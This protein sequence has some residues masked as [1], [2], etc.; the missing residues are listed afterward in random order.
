MEPTNKS[1]HHGFFLLACAVFWAMS[2][3]H[4][5]ETLASVLGDGFDSDTS[6]L[7]FSIRML[8]VI[9]AIF[10]SVTFSV[11]GFIFSYRCY[12]AIWG[13]NNMYRWWYTTISVCLVAAGMI[14]DDHVAQTNYFSGMFALILFLAVCFITRPLQAEKI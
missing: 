9:L 11:S 8:G 3:D 14:I 4:W 13:K 5:I 7:I 1:V 10:V 2:C 12:L 6:M